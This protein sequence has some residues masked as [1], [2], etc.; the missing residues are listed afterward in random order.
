MNLFSPPEL[1]CNTHLIV[2]PATQ[3]AP[4][5]ITA[6]PDPCWQMDVLNKGFILQPGAGVGYLR[7]HIVNLS[8]PNYLAIGLVHT[9]ASV[10]D[11]QWP[12]ADGVDSACC[13]K[14]DRCVHWSLLPIME[15]CS[16]S[17]QFGQRGDR[18]T[19]VLDCRAMPVLRL[20]V[21]ER[22]LVA[23]P[24]GSLGPITLCPAIAL[25]GCPAVSEDQ[26]TCVELESAPLPRG[27]DA[28]L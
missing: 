19:L 11:N 4:Y 1:R 7:C 27:W 15:P 16:R 20:L 23:H 13:W 6:R 18:V 12:G 10:R 2:R 24:L 14:G 21:N 3:A 22:L 17:V 8:Y 5:S 28:P 25:K 26:Q 9:E